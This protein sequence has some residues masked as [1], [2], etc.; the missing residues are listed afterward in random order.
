[1]D[2]ISVYELPKYLEFYDLVQYFSTCRRLSLLSE[3]ALK[4]VK[5]A[6]VKNA[7]LLH[8]HCPNIRKMKIDVCSPEILLFPIEDITAYDT[9]IFYKNELPLLRRLKCSKIPIVEVLRQLDY[10]STRYDK[11]VDYTSI[12][13]IEFYAIG[14]YYTPNLPVVSLNLAILYP[15]NIPVIKT[16]PL[17]RLT[18]EHTS[19][20]D[21]SLFEVEEL[22]VKSGN[23]S[24]LHLLPNS[25]RCLS[26][27]S[28]NITE[29]PN[30]PLPPITDLR[31][32]NFILSLAI[33]KDL[34]LNELELVDCKFHPD[35]M[36]YLERQPIQ[37]LS[38]GRSRVNF[39]YI[40]RMPL[41][42]LILV[43]V[44]I[45]LSMLPK[46]IK[47]L[48]LVNVKFK[49]LNLDLQTLDL[50]AISLDTDDLQKIA[51]LPLMYLKM[52]QCDMN[53][54][55]MRILF[56]DT[57][58]SETLREFSSDSKF[59]CAIFDILKRVPLKD[60]DIPAFSSMTIHKLFASKK[61][62]SL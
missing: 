31:L 28:N 11:Y 25:L 24:N 35:E 3:R 52:N 8:P 53:D 13:T 32:R 23:F 41:I 39:A 62:L 46:S 33:M 51:S 58:L 4:Q 55:R 22:C 56:N 1:M 44:D 45:D 16:L 38:I 57:V 18:I 20:V 5:Y 60:L 17:K 9:W 59:T 36:I 40:E 29:M 26:L 30:K 10:V 2:H 7:K 14:G 12:K 27:G 43:D 54:D 34:R 61:R 6:K 15:D 19:N 48:T 47:T 37:R 42:S 49:N 21:V 50:R